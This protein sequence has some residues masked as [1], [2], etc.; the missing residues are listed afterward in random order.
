MS[1]SASCGPASRV[2]GSFWKRSGGNPASR[3]SA[4]VRSAVRGAFSLG[5]QSTALPATSACAAC[6]AFR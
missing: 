5:F 2:A 4:C 3:K 6:T 1:A